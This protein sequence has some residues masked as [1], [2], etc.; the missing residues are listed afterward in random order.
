[1]KGFGFALY[2]IFRTLYPIPSG[3]GA[4]ESLVEKRVSKISV[5]VSLGQSSFSIAPKTLLVDLVDF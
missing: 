4:E 2:A 3:P 5:S 1:M